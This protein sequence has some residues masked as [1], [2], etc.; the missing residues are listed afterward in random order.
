MNL[1]KIIWEQ[2]IITKQLVGIKYV[3]TNNKLTLKQKL[4]WGL[5]KKHKQ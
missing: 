1:L 4:N 3:K 2:V 5:N